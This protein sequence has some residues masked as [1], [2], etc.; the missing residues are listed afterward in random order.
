MTTRD[1]LNRQAVERS[2]M[3]YS[4]AAHAATNYLTA[5][6]ADE[7]AWARVK[8]FLDGELLGGSARFLTKAEW[9]EQR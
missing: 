9:D 1:E 6:G 4:Q 3:L 2:Q 8:D 5:H 7:N